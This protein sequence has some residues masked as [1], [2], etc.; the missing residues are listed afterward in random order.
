[1][2]RRQ[3]VQVWVSFLKF[4]ATALLGGSVETSHG[5]LVKSDLSS[6]RLGGDEGG[7]NVSTRHNQI[8]L[9][10]RQSIGKAFG[11]VD[12]VSVVWLEAL[13][14]TGAATRAHLT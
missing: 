5:R 13:E 4:A 11:Q 3:S 7:I 8:V 2:G 14:V 6:L 9:L 10:S 12:K 1:M